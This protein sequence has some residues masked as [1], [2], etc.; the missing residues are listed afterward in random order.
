MDMRKILILTIMMTAT[1]TV[2]AQG[3]WHYT[4]SLGGEYKS[5]NVNT[6]TFNNS[7]F[8]NK[9]SCKLS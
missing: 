6:F 4:F 3:K 5:G 2:A 8:F 1:L 7:D 9:V